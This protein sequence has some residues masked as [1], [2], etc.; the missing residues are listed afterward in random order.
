MR[1]IVLDGL[2]MNTREATHDYL[3]RRLHFPSYYGRNLDALHDLLT[4]PCDPTQI[5]LYRK[6]CML[7]KLGDYGEILLTVL[8][9]AASENASLRFAEDN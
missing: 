9:D 8:R 3:A 1:T 2:Y 4:E 5:I 6:A 7:Q